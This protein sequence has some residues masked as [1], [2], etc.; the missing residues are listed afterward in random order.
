MHT[1]PIADLLTRLRNASKARHQTVMAP[2]SKMKKAILE[3]LAT[4]GFIAEVKT[5]P[6]GKIEQL[7]VT[8]L[9]DR[10][11]LQLKRV[12][13]PGQRRYVSAPD[14][15]PVRNGYGIGIISTSA[16]LMTAQEAKAKGV[17]GEYICQ[18][19]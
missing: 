12:S 3:I 1:D 2:N 7:V 5:Q 17:G 15:R 14:I 8:L 19:F 6:Q 4:H 18:V 11:P 9:T 10:P 16:G 13:K